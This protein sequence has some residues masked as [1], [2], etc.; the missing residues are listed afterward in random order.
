MVRR[1]PTEDFQPQNNLEEKRNQG[2]KENLLDG[3]T[4]LCSKLSPA[5]SLSIHFRCWDHALEGWQRGR[6]PRVDSW[7]LSQSCPF[8]LGLPVFSLQASKSLPFL[9]LLLAPTGAHPDLL[10]QGLQRMPMV[11][12]RAPSWPGF[13]P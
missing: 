9:G 4:V 12:S 7:A 10:T 11:S 8:N 6:A 2:S 5:L 13:L 1:K 3:N